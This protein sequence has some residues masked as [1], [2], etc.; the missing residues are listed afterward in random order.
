M[1]YKRAVALGFV[2]VLAAFAVAA[3]FYPQLPDT[4]PTHWNAAGQPDDYTSKPWGPFIL[5]LAMLGAWIA[6][7][8]LPPIA[9]RGYRL[10]R[11]IGTYGILMLAMLA[12]LLVLTIV[13]L[14]AADGKQF[15]STRVAFI[16][17]G[18]LFVVLGNYL[19][20]LRKNFF[21][22]IRTPWTL[23]SDEVWARTHRLGGW[24]FVL[25]GLAVVA[26]GTLDLGVWPFMAAVGSAALVPAI[27]SYLAYRQV[28]R[29]QV[30]KS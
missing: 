26:I 8:V 17:I 5:P 10:D 4:V 2:L 21:I 16:V 9:P 3:W 7:S 13:M 14:L 23:A 25:A 30:G 27:Y 29:E 11:F 24:L 6:L 19:G 15:N 12:A 22:G 28:E 1:T 18:A 20:K